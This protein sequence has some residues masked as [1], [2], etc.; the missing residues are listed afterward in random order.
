M[1]EIDFYKNEILYYMQR[2][3]LF[4]FNIK[5]IRTIN[6]IINMYKQ[7]IRIIKNEQNTSTCM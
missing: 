1:T 3:R 2:K 5:K 7:Y 6:G 4:L